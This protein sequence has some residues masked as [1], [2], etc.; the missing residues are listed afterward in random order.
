MHAPSP[1]FPSVNC[2]FGPPEDR[3]LITGLHTVVDIYCNNCEAL[4]GWKYEE[5]YEQSQ[6]YKKGKF[7]LEKAKLAKE[8]W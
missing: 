6:K 8:N 4:L 7:I 2:T 3:I 5:A 1:F